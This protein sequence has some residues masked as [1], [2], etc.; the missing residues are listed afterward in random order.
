MP[1]Y[2]VYKLYKTPVNTTFNFGLFIVNYGVRRRETVSLHACLTVGSATIKRDV[3]HIVL[4]CQQGV[5]RTVNKK[6]NVLGDQM[7]G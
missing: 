1:V 6:K 2:P 5:P 4:H 7:L 3:L